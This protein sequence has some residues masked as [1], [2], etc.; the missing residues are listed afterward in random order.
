MSGVDNLRKCTTM[1]RA[2]QSFVRLRDAW[3]HCPCSGA[4]N[5]DKEKGYGLRKMRDSNSR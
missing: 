5:Q 1:C 4:M 2:R 3:T